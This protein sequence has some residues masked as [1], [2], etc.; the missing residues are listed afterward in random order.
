MG[1]SHSVEEYGVIPSQ[2]LAMQATRDGKNILSIDKFG[3]CKVHSING[4]QCQ[5]QLSVIP[6]TCSVS[7]RGGWIIGFESGTLS[8]FDLNL[9]LIQSFTIPGRSRAHKSPITTVVPVFNTPDQSDSILCIS[10]ADST[11]NFWSWNGIRLYTLNA[12]SPIQGLCISDNLLFIGESKKITP[13]DIDSKRNLANILIPSNVYS[14]V[15]IPD[16][17]GILV[18]T[19]DGQVLILSEKSIVAQFSFFNKPPVRCIVPLK[20]EEETGLFSY[21]C[22]NQNGEFSIRCLEF[23]LTEINNHSS[24]KEY[25]DYLPIFTYNEDTVFVIQKGKLKEIPIY[26]LAKN[27]FKNLPETELPRNSIV[28]FYN[29]FKHN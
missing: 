11:I 29:R 19:D 16:V 1:S 6:T 20:V 12:A 7:P 10:A 18:A 9:T 26:S 21:F 3:L 4:N 28:N 25:K 13:I 27:S 2:L 14:M 22:I 24:D 23:D 17:I 15:P 8:E 5:R